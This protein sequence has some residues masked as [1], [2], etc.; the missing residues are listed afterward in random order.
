MP[1]LQLLIITLVLTISLYAKDSGNCDS[2]VVTITKTQ[3]F[4]GTITP[5]KLSTRLV[6]NIVDRDYIQTSNELSSLS[7]VL[8]KYEKICKNSG[9]SINKALEWDSIKRKNIFVGY[10][11][12]LNIQCTYNNAN[13]IEAIYNEP[14]VKKLIKRNQSVSVSNKGTRWIVSKS[15]IEKKKEALENKA[16]I[17]SGDFAKRLSRLLK[18][19]CFIKSINLSTLRMRPMP[20]L[21]QKMVLSKGMASNII[22]SAEPSKQDTILNYKANYIFKC[23]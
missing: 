23:K 8:K 21:L 19:R 13:Q 16:I 1:I 7:N 4:I 9:Y 15:A 14:T 22:K 3:E 17:Y 20:I 10:R 12:V 6:F 2:N 5:D 18:K 11:G